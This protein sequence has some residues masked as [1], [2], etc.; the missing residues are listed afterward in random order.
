MSSTQ[1]HDA[2]QTH[3]CIADP[4][5]ATVTRTAEWYATRLPK[6]FAPLT[7][8]AISQ[9]KLFDL[10]LPKP[11]KNINTMP[12]KSDNVDAMQERQCRCRP[13]VSIPPRQDH[14]RPRELTQCR[15]DRVAQWFVGTFFPKLATDRLRQISPAPHLGQSSAS[16]DRR[17]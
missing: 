3:Q 12:R 11:R 2:W 17:A 7:L 4:P 1:P 10:H 14:Q 6:V 16:S 5:S 8:F 13:K 9:N 15:E